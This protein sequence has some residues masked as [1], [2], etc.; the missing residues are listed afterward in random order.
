[1]ASQRGVARAINISMNRLQPLL[2]VFND[3]TSMTSLTAGRDI[4]VISALEQS[5]W[6]YW[7]L[8]G[9]AGWGV[10]IGERYVHN[11]HTSPLSISLVF[12]LPFALL[13]YGSLVWMMVRS[14]RKGLRSSDATSLIAPVYLTGALIHSLFAY[15]LFVDLLVF[16]FAGVVARNLSAAGSRSSTTAQ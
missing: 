14:F 6:W 15:S 4:E 12:G 16:F 7:I 10:D 8:G 5:R 13:L 2:G 3:Q 11:I 1:M 9:G